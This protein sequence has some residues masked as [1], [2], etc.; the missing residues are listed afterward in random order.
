MKKNLTQT[1]IHSLKPQEK[2]YEVFDATCPGLFVVI[3]KTKKMYYLKYDDAGGRRHKHKIGEAG[4]VLTVAQA[5]EAAND[6]KARLARKENIEPEKKPDSISL[7]AFISLYEPERVREHKAG[8]A[9][10]NMMR[11]AF[12]KFLPKKMDD[13]IAK[14]FLAWRN[15]RLDGGVKR[16]TVN[17][18]IVALRAAFNWG[19]ENKVI[20]ANPLDGFKMLKKD[21][22][23]IVRY[24]DDDERERLYAALDAREHKIRDTRE[25]NNGRL[26]EGGLEVRP[27]ID[28]E[29]ADYLK[30]MVILTLYT[31]LRRGSL[32]LLQWGDVDFNTGY[33]TLESDK[34]KSGTKNNKT[35]RIPMNETAEATLRAWH[36]QCTSTSPSDYVFTSPKTG[37]KFDNITTS[38]EN[39]L[40]MAN[41]ENFRFHDLR[42][43]YASR[44]AMNGILLNTIRVLLGHSGISTTLRYAHLSPNTERE[45]VKSLDKPRSQAS[46][47][48]RVR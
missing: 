24:L 5:R 10:V 20:A 45:A 26:A 13:L 32:F 29:F 2:P 35:L 23:E 38:W 9:T 48:E 28:G 31:G 14:D 33:I 19:V 16:V 30:P 21:E 4:D 11:S 37:G 15:E 25:N 8:Q 41:I 42:H 34:H 6:L 3:G 12:S 27:A 17:K 7:G 47:S 36:S 43:D 22:K 18:N 39:L 46:K 1:I 40:K 44:L